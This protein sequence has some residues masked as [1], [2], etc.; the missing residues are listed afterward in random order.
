MP[1][2]LS[3]TSPPAIAAPASEGLRCFAVDLDKSSIP[4]GVV[5]NI[6]AFWPGVFCRGMTTWTGPP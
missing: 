1:W 6:A 4:G 3:T 5:T 2:P